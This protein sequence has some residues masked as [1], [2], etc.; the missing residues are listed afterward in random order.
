M[1][2]VGATYEHEWRES[3]SLRAS[4]TGVHYF[5]DVENVLSSRF[6]AAPT[7]SSAFLTYGD[8]VER[9]LQLEADFV[10]RHNSGFMV[11]F[12][13]FGEVGDLNV[14][15]AQLSLSKRF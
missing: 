8:K 2:G 1:V 13:G 14:Y 15:G 7:G 10:Y 12:G 6:A 9:Q 4:A 5:G 11:S 3:L